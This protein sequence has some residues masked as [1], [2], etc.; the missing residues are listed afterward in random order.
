MLHIF[1]FMIVSVKTCNWTL[2]IG[3]I[4]CTNLTLYPQS[5]TEKNNTEVFATFLD[6]IN[7]KLHK[8]KP[9]N[10]LDYYEGIDLVQDIE[11]DSLRVQFY[12]IF[13]AHYGDSGQTELL[14]SL[15][16]KALPILKKQKDYMNITFTYVHL[17]KTYI[18][19]NDRNNFRRIC[20]ETVAYYDNENSDHI[21]KYSAYNNV[22]VFYHE[23]L[24]EYDSA[25]YFYNKILQYPEALRTHK[26]FSGSVYDNIALVHMRKGEFNKARDY[27][28][29]NYINIYPAFNDGE[30]WM[31]AGI[32]WADTDIKLGNL[33]EANRILSRVSAQMDSLGN[34]PQKVLN[35]IL[36][37]HTYE[38]YYKALGD[39]KKVISYSNEAS[40]LKDS[41]ERIDEKIRFDTQADLSRIVMERSKKSYEQEKI[42]RLKEEEKS[43]VTTWILIMSIAVFV[44]FTFVIMSHYRF[45]VRRAKAAKLIEEERANVEKLKNEVLQGEIASKKQDLV[46]FAVNISYNQK[47]AKELLGR[48]KEIKQL[49]GRSKGKGY[50]ILEKEIKSKVMAEEEIIDFQNRVDLLSNEFYHSLKL[51]FPYLT[52]SEIKLCSLIRLNIDNPEIAL[53]QNINLSSVYQNRSRLRTRMNL[54]VDQDLDTFISE[55]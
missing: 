26:H 28:S 1:V 6:R 14:V 15:A 17:A 43:K 39:Y 4:L 40:R 55:I 44:L 51:Q 53:I 35:R 24:K 9:L 16:N 7:Q 12:N 54:N 30:R 49:K 13:L 42:L 18:S 22:G 10:A 52:K 20:A 41:V 45:R 48:I 38:E 34:Y 21:M 27:F 29:N 8:G 37:A 3:I 32:Q 25:M 5:F 2:L 11:S 50:E 46:D 36:L 23:F 47:W 31:R 33:P 19:D